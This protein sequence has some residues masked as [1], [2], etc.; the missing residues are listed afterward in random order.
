MPWTRVM[1]QKTVVSDN[2]GLGHISPPR[3]QLYIGFGPTK[4][5]WFFPA[6][7]YGFGPQAMLKIKQR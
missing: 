6:V 1:V 3:W 5:S 2:A 7:S 4:S